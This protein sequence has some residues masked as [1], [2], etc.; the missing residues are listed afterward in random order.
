MKGPL[1]D[2]NTRP[3]MRRTFAFIVLSLGLALTGCAQKKVRVEMS[4]T[5]EG[6]DRSFATN[7]VD[8]DGRRRLSEVYASSAQTD[9]ATGGVRFDG[10]FEQG[11][12]SELG[13]RNGLTERRS[14]LGSA[15]FYFES[16]DRAATAQA[17]S[18]RQASG[19]PEPEPHSDWTSLQQR[20]AAGELWVRLFARW[21]EQ[22]IDEGRREEFRAWV[23]EALVPF[24]NDFMLRY[25]AMQAVAQSARI[26]GRIRERGE[27]GPRSDDESFYLRVFMP[28]LLVL[29]S[30]GGAPASPESLGVRSV[31]SGIFTPEEL[32]LLL[33][34]SLDG[35]A[36]GRSRDWS[37]DRIFLPAVNRHV[38]RWK[39][40]AKPL[41]YTQLTIAGF[42]FLLW[43]GSS[44]QRDDILLA[45]SAIS[46]SE[47]ARVRNGDRSIRLP[48][49]YGADPR[50]SPKA[51]E[52][53]VRLKVAEAPYLT[54][55]LWS[56]ET[57]E[58]VF[59]AKF[60]PPQERTVLYQPIFY[61]A[62]TAPDESAQRSSFG[63]VVLR[64]EA[65]AQFVIWREM[66]TDRRRE[67]LDA[68]L[69]A[70]ADGDIQPLRAIVADAAGR[71][72]APEPLRRWVEK[73]GR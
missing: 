52:T 58:V 43:A 51:M 33:L 20:M 46:E 53:E 37:L 62:W 15:W 64:S 36:G 10:R 32:Q 73:K 14:P 11:L 56:A 8:Q 72:E 61:A 55:G 31:A 69:L 54:N 67:G 70:A 22:Q 35:N 21:A 13:N 34:M 26:G 7:A 16:F 66:M 71:R 5:S 49:P 42:G 18:T 50:R 40:D 27:R 39:P 9:S 60:F 4:A 63:E 25:G 24:A 12:P 41:G 17:T 30:E 68:A 3:V 47:K 19:T 57:S 44:P 6:V 2:R 23:D 59:A 65:L 48:S 45:S 28:L 29:G 38:Q 1:Y